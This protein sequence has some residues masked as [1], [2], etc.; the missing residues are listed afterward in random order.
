MQISG[1]NQNQINPQVQYNCNYNSGNYPAEQVNVPNQAPVQYVQNPNPAQYP[2]TNPQYYYPQPQ[3]IQQPQNVQVPASTAGVN[4]QIF[5]P[6]V[7]TPGSMGPTYNVNA[8]SYPSNYYTGQYGTN[9][10]NQNANG[11][12]GNGNNNNGNNVNT[13]TNSNTSTSEKT[14]AE[15]TS[16]DGTK[17]QKRRIVLLDDNYIKTLE[18]YLNS[19]DKSTRLNAAKDV[20]ER[21]D[22]DPSRK[23]DKALTALINKMLQD[24][25]QEIRLIALSALEGRIVNGDEFTVQILKNM[26]TNPQ[27]QG[28]DSSDASKI[29]LQMAGKRVDKEVET[30]PDKRTKI[31]KKKKDDKENKS[32]IKHK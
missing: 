4:I 21:L 17:K 9:G 6:S 26:Q 24:P 5:N 10:A 23:D 18:N 13:N 16:E 22:E 12:N 27:G 14:Q 32:P 31:K 8:P 30:D 25:N 1:Q 20:F 2:V 11:T 29:L 15:F 19:Q 7:A 3:Y 28:F